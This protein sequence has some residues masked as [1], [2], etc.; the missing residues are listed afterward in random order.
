MKWITTDIPLGQNIRRLRKQAGMTQAMA[1]T[2]LQLQGSTMSRST[3]S[4][5][6]TGRRNIKASDLVLLKEI[7]HAG[8]DEFFKSASEQN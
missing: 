1:A 7:F 5:I 3:L 8:Y 2:R 4:N 6:E